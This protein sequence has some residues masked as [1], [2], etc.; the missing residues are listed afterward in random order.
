MSLTH[1]VEHSTISLFTH[2]AIRAL[3]VNPLCGE[4]HTVDI[5]TYIGVPIYECVYLAAIHT[6]I[7]H[8]SG[9]RVQLFHTQSYVHDAL[10]H[11]HTANWRHRGL[12]DDIR[13][14]GTHR[15]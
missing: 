8:P 15:E 11:S 5:D 4:I 12:G 7:A 2:S 10:P 14:R 9:S 3:G 6:H 1:S 13:G